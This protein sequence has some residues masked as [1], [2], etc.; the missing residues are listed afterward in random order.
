MSKVISYLPANI[1]RILIN[2][3]IVHPKTST[4]I[5]RAA[6]NGSEDEDQQNVEFREKYMFDAYL[7]GFCDDV[8]RVLAKK[9]FGS[10]ANEDQD[11]QTHYQALAS[12]RERQ[13]RKSG[14]EPKTEDDEDSDNDDAEPE[15]FQAD[16]WEFC[17]LP[18]ERVVLFPGAAPTKGNGYGDD[19]HED[20][21]S[22]VS[23][24]EVAHCDGCSKRIAGTIHKCVDCFDYE[25]CKRCYPKLSKS[26]FNGEHAF[27]DEPTAA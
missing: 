12:L 15:A 4:G 21:A 24:H 11:N 18:E 5:K 14:E 2:R 1:P 16:A 9:M 23:F 20:E 17:K 27:S 26:H 7:L 19:G 13:T 8:T 22:A 6:S 3:N 25:L 10:E